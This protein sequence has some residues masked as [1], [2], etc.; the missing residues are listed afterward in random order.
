MALDTIN[1]KNIPIFI[2][3]TYESKVDNKIRDKFEK[4]ID[5]NLLKIL[6]NLSYVYKDTFTKKERISNVRN[7]SLDMKAIDE[8]SKMDNLHLYLKTAQYYRR[9][10]R[11]SNNLN[12]IV[13]I[14]PDAVDPEVQENKE[15]DKNIAEIVDTVNEFVHKKCGNYQDKYVLVGVLDDQ[16]IFYD[17]KN[18]TLVDS[19]MIDGFH[20]EM[21]YSNPNID[22]TSDSE[23]EDTQKTK[24][25]KPNH[26]PSIYS[27]TDDSI[28]PISGRTT[29]SKSDAVDPA[30]DDAAVDPADDADPAAAAD[31]DDAV[32]PA[33]VDADVDAVP[34]AADA[35]D[36]NTEKDDINGEI[37]EILGKLNKISDSLEN[38]DLRDAVDK[39]GE[40]FREFSSTDEN[41]PKRRV[42][43]EGDK[44]VHDFKKNDTV[45]Y[46]ENGDEKT[47][48]IVAIHYDDPPNPYYTIRMRDTG[49]EPREKQTVAAKLRKI[50]TKKN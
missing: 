32:D 21:E 1:K 10:K 45:I 6:K 20:N 5:T 39:L 12:K 24:K 31:D 28:N 36:V 46:N 25:S 42:S 13:T 41:K 33:D 8:E 38:K 40:T 50:E 44:V 29:R 37:I 4:N 3:Y 18:D 47:A 19:R 34:A 30:D 14:K 17:T 16:C 22:N 27:S 7:T 15:I 35:D 11:F 23:T 9:L 26:D 48:S 43:F 2:E 49:E